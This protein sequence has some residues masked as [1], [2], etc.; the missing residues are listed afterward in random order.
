VLTLAV[1]GDLD[2]STGPLLEAALADAAAELVR[3]DELVVEL[4]GVGFCAAR[5][6]SVLRGA[7]RACGER[8]VRFALAR[9]SDPVLAVLDLLGLRAQFVVREDRPDTR[10]AVP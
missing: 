9:C 8:G 3:G 6:V 10:P 4:A 7:A 5:G 1:A 2:L